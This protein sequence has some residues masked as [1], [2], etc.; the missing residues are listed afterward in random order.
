MN[1]DDPKLEEIM[2]DYGFIEIIVDEITDIEYGDCT[3]PDQVKGFCDQRIG[4]DDEY[5]E[6][7]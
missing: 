1:Y 2:G 6:S 3:D 5:N 7:N 4:E